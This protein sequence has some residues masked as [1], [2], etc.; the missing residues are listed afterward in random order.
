[1]DPA[2]NRNEAM[3]ASSARASGQFAIGG[4]A[5]VTRLG[6]GAMRITGKGIWGEPTH[7][8]EAIRVLKRLP[9]LGVD[10]I[11]TAESYGPYISEEL[12]AEALHPYKSLFIATKGGLTRSGPD[13]WELLG[14]PEFL[15]Q[16]VMMSLRRLK[17]ERLD[18]WQLHRIDPKVPRDEQFGVIAEMLKEGLIRHAGLSQVS[19]E[20][21][22]AASK[23]FKVATV[24]NRYNLADRADEAV[25]A[26]CDSQGI[27]FVPWYPL[28]AGDLAKPGGTLDT[29]AKAHGATPGQVALAW[30]LKRSKVMLPI[31]GTS[32]VSHLEEN[33]AAADIKLSDVE[34]AALDKAA[35]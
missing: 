31:P 20:E 8:G 17:L 13:R 5:K 24:Q 1:M 6:F 12:I 14:R 4:D 11:D 15:R 28:A 7:R 18:L 21:I 9:D 27:G 26:H 10:F 29:V 16:G 32:K 19:V 25:L 35:R 22:A 2:S 3:T 30:V 34:F 33:V 23:V